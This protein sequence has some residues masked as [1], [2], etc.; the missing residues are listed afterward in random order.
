M[1]LFG[2]DK[3][4]MISD[5]AMRK[6]PSIRGQVEQ[7]SIPAKDFSSPAKLKKK[8]RQELDSENVP[9]ERTILGSDD[10]QI[11]KS[12]KSFNWA[13]IIGF[14]HEGVSKSALYENGANYVTGSPDELQFILGL[15][16]DFTYTQNLPSAFQY[17]THDEFLLQ[18]KQPVFFFDYDGTLSPIVKDPA[19]A[20]MDQPIRSLLKRL[21]I[22]YPVAIVSGRDIADIQ[23][24]VGLDNIVYA[25][26]HG[27]R[28][29]GPEG[30]VMEHEK[31]K[32]LIPMLDRIEKDI[33]HRLEPVQGIEV[34]RKYFAIAV[35]YRNAAPNSFKTVNRTVADVLKEFPDFKK[36]RG[37]KI[38][39]IRPALDWHKG[40][41]VEWIMEEMSL[42]FP[43]KHI[44]VFI[45]DDLTDED[46]FRYLG[47]NCIGI[48]VGWHD[49]PSA[50]DLQLANVDEVYQLLHVLVQ[51]VSTMVQ[52]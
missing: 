14:S 3:M 25:G 46:A 7:V 38:V 21:S 10:P 1:K 9:L 18:Q 37:K 39:E 40:K 15:N 34:E 31:A 16:A 20:I 49:Q 19:K 47:D 41:A 2:I 50:A 52:N 12:L 32:K 36:S 24:F 6:N 44:P 27:F 8:I 4:I 17:L 22:V 45:G 11:L 35:H 33:R 5:H 42:D 48:L 13:M 51:Q 26:S 29:S 28:I 23:E 43:Q 30:L